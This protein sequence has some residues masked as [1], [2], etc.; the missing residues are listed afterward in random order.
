[1][2]EE[3][4]DATEEERVRLASTVWQEKKKSRYL[5]NRYP[6]ASEGSKVMAFIDGEW[7]LATV[8]KYFD[9]RQ[10][11]KVEDSDETAMKRDDYEVLREGVIPLPYRGAQFKKGERVLAMYP[12]TTTFYPATICRIMKR[13]LLSWEYALQ[14]DGDEVDD[15]G[16]TMQKIV[17]GDLVAV[18]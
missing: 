12:G 3:I 14:F 16:E 10:V 18:E 9:K 5:Q 17:K 8:L 1:V 4:D 2:D 11:Y 7:I 6:I 15:S 13:S